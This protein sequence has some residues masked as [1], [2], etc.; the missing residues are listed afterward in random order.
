ML[1]ILCALAIAL[2]GVQTAPSYRAEIQKYRADR[3]AE[4]K[5]DD[6]WLTVAGLFWLK[7][8][9]NAAGSA[10]I[11]DIILPAK[12]PALLGTFTLE[13]GVVRFTADPSAR[14]TSGGERGTPPGVCSEGGGRGGG[15]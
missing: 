1:R 13:N 11:N 9:A 5:A 6:G 4:L 8:G 10:K 14:V 15:G 2:A 12:A 3:V 7:T